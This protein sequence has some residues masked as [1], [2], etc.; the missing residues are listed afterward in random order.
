MD[1][2]FLT[3]AQVIAASRQFV[4]VRVPTCEDQGE[5]DFLNALYRSRSGKLENTSF[6]ILSPE[7]K[8]LGRAGRGP[9]AYRGG[10]DLASSMTRI[11]GSYPGSKTA[12]WQDRQL[13]F[14]RN[15]AIG[16][17]VAASDHLPFVIVIAKHDASYA[18]L[19]NLIKS[20]VWSEQFAGQFSY[21]TTSKVAELKTVTARTIDEGIIVVK[22]EAFG[23]GGATLAEFNID[24]KPEDIK[25]K[26]SAILANYKPE[27]LDYNTHISLGA[28]LGVEWKTKIPVTD[29]QSLRAKERFRG[30]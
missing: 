12:K 3:N 22:P 13:P 6:A 4:C 26:L 30:R 28:G 11:A 10:F 5:A 24:A 16:L 27:V 20:L 15:V 19:T 9:H 7:G 23:V 29:E 1:R 8:S 2:S 21:G 25:T 17:N 14:E 18:K